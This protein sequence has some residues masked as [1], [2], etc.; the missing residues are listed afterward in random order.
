MSDLPN[1]LSYS[2]HMQLPEDP[3]VAQAV[4]KHL[5]ELALLST[6]AGWSIAIVV[7]MTKDKTDD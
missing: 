3:E 4:W 1:H 5:Q 7:T 6:S 2:L